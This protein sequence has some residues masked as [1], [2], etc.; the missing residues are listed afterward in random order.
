MYYFIY[1]LLWL[2]SLL[3]LRL[4]YVFSDACYGILF[5]I[6]KYR[7]D[8]VMSNL[9]TAFPKKTDEERLRIAKKFYHNLVDM[10]IESI[11]MISVSRSYLEKRVKGNWE[12]VNALKPTGRKVS[13]HLGHNFN[14]EWAN[15]VATKE[16]T[17]PFVG[18]YMPIKNKTFDRLFINLRSRYGTLLVRAT[19]M[20]EDMLKYRNEQYVI[21]LV[22]DQNP[23]T[24]S[25]GLW[26]NFFNKPAPFLNKPV[27]A[28]I[29]SCSAVVFAFIHKKKRGSYEVVFTVVEEA[30]ENSTD[31]ELTR[32][33]VNYMEDVIT[34][35]PDMWLWSHRRW[36]HQ[37]KEEYGPVLEKN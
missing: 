23:G 11:K 33:F 29:A 35:Y 26:F 10:F 8:I 21:G 31:V 15:A 25:S 32:K 17:M 7:R 30:A 1:G 37:W 14:W 36:K 27:K 12:V 4:L 24:P 28:A 13:I 18:A 19:N 22:T 16:F 2:L 3:P 20:R 34:R 5:Y 9:Q 6:M